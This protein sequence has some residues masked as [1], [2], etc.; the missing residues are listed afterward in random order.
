MI[1][2]KGQFNVARVFTDKLDDGVRAQIEEMC[3]QEY[4]IGSKIRIM[5]DVHKG[6]GC[7]IGT[8][9]TIQDEVVPNMVGVDI[10]CGIETIKLK[11]REI[12][13][14]K[15][16]QVIRRQIPSGFS[17]RD[18]P[19]R[20]A[21]QAEIDQLI[22]KEFVD[23][24]R[25]R[26]S[27]G[28]LG[29]GNHFI[30]VGKDEEGSLYLAVHSGSR[31]LGTQV[32]N[33]YQTQGY[34]AIERGEAVDIK[35]LV[36]EYQ[37]A[38]RQK[39]INAAI[40][41]IKARQVTVHRSMASV[42]GQL[43]QDYIHDMKIT[44]HFATLN[45]QAMVDEIVGS[46]NLHVE[47]SFTTIHNYIDTDTMILRKGAV[48]AKAGEMLLIPMNM[49]DGSLICRGKGNPD[50]NWSAPHGAG[51]LMSRTKALQELSLADFTEQM[52]G[53]Y[54]TCISKKTLDEAPGAYKDMQEILKYI[55]PTVEII[56]IIKP[57]Y[58][59]KAN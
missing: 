36:A 21:E 47:E 29:G 30:E 7:T 31:H 49:R 55:D 11:E 59:F 1:E 42:K 37:A 33:H 17:V 5:P 2:V 18:V 12:D 39:E 48:S 35:A 52:A 25:A 34:E 38:G 10:G 6:K 45:R 20:F 22:C 8:T 46:L 56:N 26:H 24:K 16:D 41:E 3:S 50:W 14:D 58:N 53:I 19:H 32:A 57:V 44:Q 28:S 51:R 9:L 15:L 23:L 43:F 13:F 27:V 40:E 4:M 54:T